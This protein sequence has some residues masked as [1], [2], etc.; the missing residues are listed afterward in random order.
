MKST[1]STS[2]WPPRVTVRGGVTGWPYTDNIYPGTAKITVEGR[3]NYGGKLIRE[4]TISA[5]LSM[6]EIAPIPAQPYTG[7][8]VTPPLTVTARTW[9]FAKSLPISKVAVFS[10]VYLLKGAAV[11]VTVAIQGC[12]RCYREI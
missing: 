9:A 12:Y 2:L 1:P 5:D 10:P 11:I 6:A 4:F 7:Q 3:N 8:P